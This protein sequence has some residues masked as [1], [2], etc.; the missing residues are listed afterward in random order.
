MQ[1]IQT[2]TVDSFTEAKDSYDKEE[3]EAAQNK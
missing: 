3:E 2:S 1:K